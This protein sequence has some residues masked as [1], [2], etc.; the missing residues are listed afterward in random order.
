MRT[1]K[2]TIYKDISFEEL[3]PI[4]PPLR[5]KWLV[6]IG[7]SLEQ[8]AIIAIE[9]A[10]DQ[11]L[12]FSLF[13]FQRAIKNYA[14]MLYYQALDE[15]PE[16]ELIQTLT[17]SSKAQLRAWGYQNLCYFIFDDDD[18]KKLHFIQD[19][20]FTK[21]WRECYLFYDRD[22][23]F[24]SPIGQK[25]EQL[26][27]IRKNVRETY[28]LLNFQKKQIREKLLRYG[29]KSDIDL[30]PDDISMYYVD[31]T[32]NVIAYMPFRITGNTMM[33]IELYIEDNRKADMALPAM[34]AEFLSNYKYRIGDDTELVL[35]IFPEHNVRAMENGF[36]LPS[37]KVGANVYKLG[38]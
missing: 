3:E 4:L 2:T 10:A 35:Q 1:Y 20:G 9:D 24:S 25:M 37:K 12:A 30:C 27:P 31:D 34:L 8:I 19:L 33:N 26:Q 16:Y 5:Y 32:E 15:A 17:R 23:L 28:S 21:A 29:F 36:G 11:M 7:S 13:V 22:T 14:I 38:L 18:I 6:D